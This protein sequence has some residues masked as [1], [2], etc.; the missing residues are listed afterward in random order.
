MRG[1][2]EELHV[3]FSG[4]VEKIINGKV[5]EVF[6][7]ND[8]AKAGMDLRNLAAVFAEYDIIE[9]I[10]PM[11]S[12]THLQSHPNQLSFHI[13]SN[14]IDLDLNNILAESTHFT[15]RTNDLYQLSAKNIDHI[16]EFNLYSNGYVFLKQVQ[17][18]T[19]I[20]TASECG[21]S[22]ASLFVPAAAN[23][24]LKEAIIITY[25][26]QKYGITDPAELTPWL[27]QYSSLLA[28]RGH[29]YS[30]GPLTDFAIPTI[31]AADTTF[32]NRYLTSNVIE[33][34]TTSINTLSYLRNME[35]VLTSGTFT[36][37]DVFTAATGT[38][39][40]PLQPVI[41]KQV[42]NLQQNLYYYFEAQTAAYANLL[43]DNHGYPLSL[44]VRSKTNFLIVLPR[45][46]SIA[47]LPN[48]RYNAM[49]SVQNILTRH[50]DIAE[51][52]SDAKVLTPTEYFDMVM[53]DFTNGVGLKGK[54]W[55]FQPSSTAGKNNME[56][57]N[58][59]KEFWE[60]SDYIRQHFN[61]DPKY[62]YWRFLFDLCQL[63]SVQT[64][65]I[66]NLINFYTILRNNLG[67]QR[68]RQRPNLIPDNYG[69]ISH[70]VETINSLYSYFCNAPTQLID[71]DKARQNYFATEGGYENGDFQFLSEDQM[72]GMF[73]LLEK[74]KQFLHD[75]SWASLN[76]W[77]IPA[78]IQFHETGF[79]PTP[80]TGLT[81]MRSFLHSINMN[82]AF[83]QQFPFPTTIQGTS[84][85]SY[86]RSKFEWDAGNLARKL[87]PHLH[88]FLSHDTIEVTAAGKLLAGKIDQTWLFEAAM[89]SLR[90]GMG[91]ELLGSAATY[92]GTS[93]GP[94]K[95]SK[96][97]TMISTQHA[98]IAYVS[99]PNKGVATYYDSAAITNIGERAPHL[100][101][102]HFEVMVE[103]TLKGILLGLPIHESLAKLGSTAVIP[104]TSQ[105]Y[106]DY[107]GLSPILIN[108]F[109]NRFGLKPTSPFNEVPPILLGPGIVNPAAVSSV[110]IQFWTNY[111]TSGMAT[112]NGQVNPFYLVLREKPIHAPPTFNPF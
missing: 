58:D 64:A 16:R 11:L 28:S 20:I 18:S 17:R 40:L 80:L 67:K 49:S 78:A 69:D 105:T 27:S 39:T 90:L 65:K 42:Y 107:F 38:S 5:Q 109:Q 108:D 56:V 8:Y 41:R 83:S 74:F 15:S 53:S 3:H 68:Q 76:A 46:L 2:Q 4:K 33:L 35:T 91:F 79:D 111:A 106:L 43:C 47:S 13:S 86:A 98:A 70:T 103:I 75:D 87:M 57:L 14:P 55:L 23:H 24:P 1:S 97:L 31:I 66:E 62:N 29:P 89:D 110:F 99:Y 54:D 63:D 96:C 50:I 44:S 104:G 22:P 92:D 51:K 10:D 30:L 6:L 48:Y 93:Y 88:N 72:N 94:L 45:V 61:S 77:F 59:F 7:I 52:F 19:R 12:S 32:F 37:N 82:F 36:Y 34:K 9:M 95:D 85:M 100:P 101:W 26:N 25:L 81:S 60:K 21:T 112:I 84:F 73:F 71:P 102:D